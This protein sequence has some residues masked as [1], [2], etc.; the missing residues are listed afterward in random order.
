MYSEE[1]FYRKITK[2]EKEHS[3]PGNTKD[4]FCGMLIFSITVVKKTG[5]VCGKSTFIKNQDHY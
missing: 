1:T 4:L 2:N 3:T 5:T